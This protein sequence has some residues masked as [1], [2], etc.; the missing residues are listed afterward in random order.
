MNKFKFIGSVETT[1][2]EKCRVTLPAK[3][4]DNLSNS[5]RIERKDGALRLYESDGGLNL[6]SAHRLQLGRDNVDYLGSKNIVMSGQLERVNG[7]LINYILIQ[8]ANKATKLEDLTPEMIS[9]IY[10]EIAGGK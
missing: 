9:D 10:E 1:I 8:N 6:D 2:D 4:R 5:L 7:I 3:F